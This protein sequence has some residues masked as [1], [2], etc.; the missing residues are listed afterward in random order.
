M[1]KRNAGRRPSPEMMVALLALSIAL[2]GTS[3]AA[4]TLPA[5]SVGAKQLKRSAVTSAKVR[6]FSL[7]AKD[8]APGQI[9]KGPAG[10]IGATG[11]TGAA[12]RDGVAGAPGQQGIQGVQGVQGVPGTGRAWASVSSTGVVNTT[13]SKDVAPGNV[14]H[15]GGANSGIYCVKGLAFEPKNV[16]AMADSD[17][18][19]ARASYGEN[20]LYCPSGQVIISTFNAAGAQADSGFQML[21]NG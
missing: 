12:G 10:P 18:Y 9:P 1:L 15:A 19:T 6:D 7:S 16:I 13:R 17:G 20:T 2:G 11:A 8:F 21:I 14:S 3:Y 4:I 5:N